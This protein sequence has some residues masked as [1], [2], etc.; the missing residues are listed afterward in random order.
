MHGPL[1]QVKGMNKAKAQ[2]PGRGERGR[3]L[4]AFLKEMNFMR[5]QSLC[6][7]EAYLSAVRGPEQQIGSRELI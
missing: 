7:G 5:L 4:S 1:L 6:L 3:L 2:K